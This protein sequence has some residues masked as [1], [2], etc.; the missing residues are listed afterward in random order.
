MYF[1]C[2]HKHTHTNKDGDK[3]NNL[4]AGG[5]EKELS[6]VIS[7]IYDDTVFLLP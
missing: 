6:A 3:S 7:L 5:C 4:N 2:R 1:V